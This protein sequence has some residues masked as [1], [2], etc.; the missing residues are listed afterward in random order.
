VD[1]SPHRD[2]RVA[3]AVAEVVAVVV[4]MMEMMTTMETEMVM[5]RLGRDHRGSAEIPGRIAMRQPKSGGTDL[6]RSPFAR[7]GS[8]RRARTCSCAGFL[9]HASCA[10]LHWT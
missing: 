3:V 7:S 1:T 5:V 2:D 9:L 6:A 4:A 8:T 10:R